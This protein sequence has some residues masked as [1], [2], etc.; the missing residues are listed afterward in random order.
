MWITL[1]KKE[2]LAHGR[3]LKRTLRERS[4]AG[5]ERRVEDGR[6]AVLF[7]PPLVPSAVGRARR[8]LAYGLKSAYFADTISLWVKSA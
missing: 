7:L 8:R 6:G 5:C 3:I 4:G 1:R 2:H